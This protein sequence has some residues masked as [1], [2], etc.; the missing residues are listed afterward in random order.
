M[1]CKE[2]VIDT[3]SSVKEVLT[4]LKGFY[5]E[6]I[7]RDIINIEYDDDSSQYTEYAKKLPSAFRY[8]MLGLTGFNNDFRHPFSCIGLVRYEGVRYDI[9]T[10]KYYLW[11]GSYHDI[12]II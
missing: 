9:N 8:Q 1:P 4:Q 11:L 2:L 3:R 5:C 7:T 12:Y 10:K 6:K